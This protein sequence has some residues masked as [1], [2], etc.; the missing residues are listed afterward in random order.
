MAY[1]QLERLLQLLC[2]LMSGTALLYGQGSVTIFGTVTDA[3]GAAVSGATVTVLSTE[4]GAARQTMSSVDGGYVIS[5]LPIGLYS[6]S[7]EATGFKKFVL[8]NIRVAVDE[9]RR[10]NIELQV[11]A[12]TE[13][14]TV[15]AEAAEVE[16]RSG[17][18][19]EVIDSARIVELPLNGR[20]PLQLQYLV[21]GSGGINS[22]GQEQNDS[23]SIN[24][25]RPNTNNYTLDG[26]DN[27]DPY[28]N[29][30]SIFPNPD[31]LEE[32]SLQTSSYAADRG[33]NAGAI[34][35]AVTRS[36]TKV[37]H[38]T[39][40][41]FVRN[42]KLN[43]R[44]FFSATVPP[45]KRNQFGG[46]VGGPI[47][48]DKTFFF[49]SYQHTAERS[50]PGSVNPT[51]LSTAQRQ[52]DWSNAGLRTP[53]KDPLGGT[54]PNNIIPASRLNKASQNFLNAFVPIPTRPDG[55]YPFASQQKI[56][57]DQAVGKI[58][59]IITENNR[60][61]G[62]F[63]YN[64]NG[65]YQV[66]NNTSLPGFLALIKYR[67]YSATGTDTYILSPRLI[68]VFT[69]GYN[70]IDRDQV[71]IVPGNKSWVDFGAGFVRAYPGDPDVGFDTNVNGYFRP[72]A[73]YPLHHYRKS[74]Q[75]SEG[76]NWT[77]GAHFLRYGVDIRR[78]LLKLQENFQCDP[79]VV[80]RATFTGNAAADLLLGLPTTFTQIAPTSNNPR[81]TEIGAYIQDDWK[82]SR[83]LT[84]NLGLRWDPF[85]PNSDPDRRFAQ[86]RLGQQSV[87]F[88]N[89]PVGYVF[90]RDPGVPPSTIETQYQD[91]GPRFGF[92]FDPAGNGRMSIRGGYGIFYSQVRQQANNQVSNDQPFAIQLS[93][94]NPTGG[95][96]RPYADTGNP[97][98][99]DA[100]KTQ[101]EMAAYKFLL[102]LNVTQWDWHFRNA[103][104]QQWNLTVQ[105]QLASNWVATAAYVGS[106][107]NHLFVGRELN[108]AVYG[109]PGKTVDSR[110]LYYPT[111][112]NITNQTSDGSS[113][114]HALQ[115]TINKRL[116]HGLTVLANYTWSKL[117]DLGSGDGS[118]PQNT[119]DIRADRGPSDNDV[120][121][122]FVG[123]F[124]YELPA[125][126]NRTRLVREVLGGWE[127]NGIATLWSSTPLSVTSGADN[128]GTAVNQ[129]RPNVVGDW[130]I[131]GDRSKNARILQYFNTA[132]FVQNPAGTFGNAGRNILR[133]DFREN[134]DLGAIKNFPITERHR[135]QFRGEFF[136]VTNHANLGNPNGNVSSPT[137]GR[138]TGAGNPRVIQL[139]LKY[140]F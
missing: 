69:F 34:M 90:P 55:L 48:K 123:S 64:R 78:D 126:R 86:V 93:V 133:G 49:G 92:A 27:H 58:D 23:V 50:S 26:A 80:F 13:S 131:S 60:L 106:K 28:F 84:L 82:V 16:T 111:F 108:P 2:L 100:P 42:E 96:D 57:D 46:T 4:T 11:G 66:A 125:L 52:G 87:R 130:H 41:E 29:T 15:Q 136:N 89:A 59:H 110:R 71:S 32:F 94:T 51:L 128:S 122:R 134:L 138:I 12:I 61:S 124:I 129:D 1:K 120:P 137:F 76:M 65:N 132:A 91:W 63:L 54:F 73:R 68:N 21:A 6:V 72:Q 7:A 97:F 121:H 43:A 127:I 83:R 101:Q 39:L 95:L 104:A 40:F 70:Q 117:I 5:Q 115:L 112:T 9:N 20:N 25:S 53:L 98:P 75:F 3:S 81:T 77:R 17:A 62:R 99:F 38:A 102:P 18:L 30:P 33:R 47:R 31:A 35:N 88:P 109:R 74:F 116:T 8:G 44:N 37:L 103:I 107:G 45:F 22:A 140:M 10:V 85:F 14:V 67:N 139:A 24:G 19:R 56:D 114:Y 113:I 36:G 118:L 119:F 105:R 135:L 79:A